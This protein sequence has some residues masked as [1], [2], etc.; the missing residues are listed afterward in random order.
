MDFKTKSGRSLTIDTDKWLLSYKKKCNIVVENEDDYILQNANQIEITIPK[1]IINANEIEIVDNSIVLTERLYDHYFLTPFRQGSKTRLN[2]IF[3]KN[4]ELIF[5]N[6]EIVL[7]KAEYYLIR[8]KLL[9]SGGAYIGGFTYTLGALFES[10]NSGNHIYF[11]EI[12][13]HKKLYL[14][15][16]SGSP[17]SGSYYARFWSD[18]DYKFITSDKLSMGGSLSPFYKTLDKFKDMVH[19]FSLSIDFQDIAILQLIEE[20]TKP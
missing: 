9:N 6:R 15:N 20:I 17:L 16:I 19:G 3:S 13:G 18:H 8:P 12:S 11:D 5:R 4:T 10:M 2:E 14:I 7:Q 1:A